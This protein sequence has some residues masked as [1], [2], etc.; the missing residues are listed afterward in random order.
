VTRNFFFT[1]KNR[2]FPYYEVC[3][4]K[5]GLV[6]LLERK[7]KKEKTRHPAYVSRIPEGWKVDKCVQ[8]DVVDFDRKPQ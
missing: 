1:T 4:R 6:Y 8:P 7:A 3:T 2:V 5:N